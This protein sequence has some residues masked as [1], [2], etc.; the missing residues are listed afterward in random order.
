M[1]QLFTFCSLDSWAPVV[2]Y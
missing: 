2:G 1:R